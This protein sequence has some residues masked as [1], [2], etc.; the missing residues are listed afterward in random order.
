[1]LADR[2]SAGN[3]YVISRCGRKLAVLMGADEY[4][5]LKALEEQQ[6]I[7]DFDILLHLV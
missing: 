4:R 5:R 2:A 6:R 1:M 7:K 3:I